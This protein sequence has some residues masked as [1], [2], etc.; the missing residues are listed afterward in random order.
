MNVIHLFQAVLIFVK[1]NTFKFTIEEEKN[2]EKRPTN[3]N[4]IE[5]KHYAAHLMH[6]WRTVEKLRDH[7]CRKS[8]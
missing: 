8:V 6:L 7:C 3:T 2:V 5:E 1:I 4:K